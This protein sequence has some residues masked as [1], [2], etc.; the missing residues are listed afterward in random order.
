MNDKFITS[1]V[2]LLTGI[3]VLGGI[4]VILSNQAN[5]GNVIVSFGQAIVCAIGSAIYPVTGIKP[6]CAVTTSVTSVFNPQ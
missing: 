2:S 4:A 6:N 1:A 3:I 5:T